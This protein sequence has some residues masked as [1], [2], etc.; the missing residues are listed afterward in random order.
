MQRIMLILFSMGQ[1]SKSIEY[2][3]KLAKEYD[4]FLYVNFIVQE[5]IP[6]TLSSLLMHTAYLGKKLRRDME[7]ILLKE[8]YRRAEEAVKEIEELAERDKIKLKSEIVKNGSL[9]YCY[10]EIIVENIDYLVINY[11]MDRFMSVQTLDYYIN[12]FLNNLSI[13]YKIIS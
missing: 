2:S 7:G 10:Q 3:L 5:K 8:Y 12:D 13:P 1:M 9:K 4:S 6:E 11:T